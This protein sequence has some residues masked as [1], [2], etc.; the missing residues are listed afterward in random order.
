MC[1]TCWG[2]IQIYKVVGSPVCDVVAN[3]IGGIGANIE[4]LERLMGLDFGKYC[5][6]EDPRVSMEIS[7]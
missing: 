3:D 5:V 2:E 6:T 7:P 1:S 4:G